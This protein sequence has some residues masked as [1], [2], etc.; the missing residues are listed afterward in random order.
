MAPPL[1]WA[2]SITWVP[3]PLCL[4]LSFL[5]LP[6]SFSSICFVCMNH[7]FFKLSVLFVQN[8]LGCLYISMVP[9]NVAPKVS[10]LC[11]KHPTF[12]HSEWENNLYSKCTF[13]KIH[14]YCTASTVEQNITYNTSPML[15]TLGDLL[16]FFMGLAGSW[17]HGLVVLLVED[18]DL[19]PSTQVVAPNHL[20]LLFQGIWWPLLMSVGT[21]CERGGY[22]HGRKH[23]CT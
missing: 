22:A 8:H 3:T 23:A 4:L 1:F 7:L 16:D 2:E 11:S 17:S 12:Q 13:P 14:I 20:W 5:P 6:I 18:L 10:S 19:V 15:T 9:F 21:R